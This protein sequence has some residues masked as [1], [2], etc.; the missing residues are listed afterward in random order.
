MLQPCVH[1][2]DRKSCPLE[3]ENEEVRLLQLNEQLQVAELQLYS[4][5]R[6]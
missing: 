3:S 6:V 2:S 1:D 5:K 4:G